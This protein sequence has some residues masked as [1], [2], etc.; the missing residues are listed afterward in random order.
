MT[1]Y[2]FR[3]QKW[4]EL[5][6]LRAAKLLLSR[7]KHPVDF[8]TPHY[9]IFFCICPLNLSYKIYAFFFPEN[10]QV[11]Y[12]HPVEYVEHAEPSL[13]KLLACFCQRIIVV[14]FK[15]RA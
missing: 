13:D 15:Q 6:Q 9:K 8:I 10:V 11:T 1:A 12:T 4:L 3:K 5:F 14:N 2:Q 7:Q